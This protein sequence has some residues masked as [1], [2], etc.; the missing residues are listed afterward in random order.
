VFAL[1]RGAGEGK[2]EGPLRSQ[3]VQTLTPTLSRFAAE[4]EQGAQNA[5]VGFEDAP[6]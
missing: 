4:G 6:L 2:G 1:A 3:E 5:R